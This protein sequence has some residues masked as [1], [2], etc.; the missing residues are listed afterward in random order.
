MI[1]ISSKRKTLISLPSDLMVRGKQVANDHSVSFSEYV[2]LLLLTD[3]TERKK[4]CPKEAA[5]RG[6]R[7]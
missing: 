5:H 7:R 4:D 3:L 1:A 2:A 6:A